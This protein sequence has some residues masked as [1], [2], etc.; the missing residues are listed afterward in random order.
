MSAFADREPT[1]I[2][3]LLRTREGGYW[4]FRPTA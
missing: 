2:I 1:V 4:A 3:I